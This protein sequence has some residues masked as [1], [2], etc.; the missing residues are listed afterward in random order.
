VFENRLLKSFPKVK[1]KLAHHQKDDNRIPWMSNTG[2][3]VLDKEAFANK[4]RNQPLFSN[5]QYPASFLSSQEFAVIGSQAV[6]G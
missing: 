6:D 1:V 4:S 2:C 3:R 5:I